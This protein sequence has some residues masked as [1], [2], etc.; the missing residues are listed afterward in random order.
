MESI[1]KTFKWVRRNKE[2]FSVHMRA[3]ETGEVNTLGTAKTL[4]VKTDNVDIMYER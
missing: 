3:F 2:Q 1:A 4:S